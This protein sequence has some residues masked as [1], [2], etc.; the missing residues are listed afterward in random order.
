[1]RYI[2]TLSAAV[3]LGLWLFSMGVVLGVIIGIR[4]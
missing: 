1:M 3:R 4:F 2:F